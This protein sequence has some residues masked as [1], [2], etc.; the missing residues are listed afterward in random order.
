MGGATSTPPCA[1]AACRSRRRD[2]P[3]LQGMHKKIELPDVKQGLAY[4]DLC[5]TAS[6]PA[7]DFGFIEFP[8]ECQLD[9]EQV[10]RARNQSINLVLTTARV[11]DSMWFV[12][13]D[14]TTEYAD[15]VLTLWTPELPG[16]Q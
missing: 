4:C 13:I 5:A 14:R 11:G 9:L 12:S 8:G 3:Q 6:D 16:E 2:G 15:D 7:V 10:L 1:G